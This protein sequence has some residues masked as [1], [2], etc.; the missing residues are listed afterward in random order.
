MPT[1]SSSS[2]LDNDAWIRKIYAYMAHRTESGDRPNEAYVLKNAGE[3][4]G[5]SIGFA[6]VDLAGTPDARE[7]LIKATQ[8]WLLGQGKGADPKWVDGITRQLKV[9]GP[10]ATLSTEYRDA[11]NGYLATAAGHTLADKLSREFM[12]FAMK[13]RGKDIFDDPKAAKLLQDPQSLAFI[14]KTINAGDPKTLEDYI[15]GEKIELAGKPERVAASGLVIKQNALVRSF[16]GKLKKPGYILYKGEK[17]KT[18][19]NTKTD[20]TVSQTDFR[21]GVKE[22]FLPTPEKPDEPGLILTVPDKKNNRI[23]YIQDGEKRGIDVDSNAKKLNPEAHLY[24]G[25]ILFKDVR[26]FAYT[27]RQRDPKKVSAGEPVTPEEFQLDYAAYNQF[28]GSYRKA[29]ELIYKTDAKF[30]SDVEAMP[31]L[32]AEVDWS[33]WHGITSADYLPANVKAVIQAEWRAKD[34]GKRPFDS[35]LV[36]DYLKTNRRVMAEI[37]RSYLLQPGSDPAKWTT[38]PIT[39]FVGAKKS[40]NKTIFYQIPKALAENGRE[41]LAKIARSPSDLAN[42]DV[43]AG[44]DKLPSEIEAL[45]RK[46][47]ETQAAT[48]APA[49]AP[50]SAPPGPRLSIKRTKDKQIPAPAQ[51]KLHTK[52]SVKPKKASFEPIDVPFSFI[53][54][55]GPTP[56][57]RPPG[58]STAD[59]LARAADEQRA[60]EVAAFEEEEERLAKLVRAEIQNYAR[61]PRHGWTPGEEA[62][63]CGV[64]IRR[65]GG[66]RH[67]DFGDLFA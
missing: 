18:L 47:A 32:T 42:L 31:D 63:L 59:Q 43:A 62:A 34:K 19:L 7:Q 36:E 35:A 4:S 27:D 6:Q 5:F 9:K 24:T 11:I 8:G 54:I 33:I 45:R 38:H 20:I 56:F 28:S 41:G 16:V 66:Y 13:D 37:V 39:Y 14:L 51:R 23:Q 65:P 57:A 12:V 50:A 26:S 53:P 1:A 67:R 10:S 58:P 15:K 44:R 29:Y 25:R 61:R 17:E 30:F 64:T 48:P 3:N 49:A 2:P 40:E 60:A 46:A 52:P 22:F 21:V 55:G